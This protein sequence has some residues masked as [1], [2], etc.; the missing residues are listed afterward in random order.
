MENGKSSTPTTGEF[1]PGSD[2][3]LE[4]F[5][6]REGFIGPIKPQ[7]TATSSGCGSSLA[8]DVLTP[9]SDGAS[10]EA[11]CCNVLAPTCHQQAT[12]IR[13]V[14]ADTG[15]VQAAVPLVPLPAGPSPAHATEQPMAVQCTGAWGWLRTLHDILERGSLAVA[16]EHHQGAGSRREG[17]GTSS[18]SEKAS[19][20]RPLSPTPS[21]SHDTYGAASDA[22][23]S[24]QWHPGMPRRVAHIF[25]GP[26]QRADGLRQFTWLVYG[27]EVVEFDTLIDPVEGN[28]LDDGVLQHLLERIRAGE[29]AL[30]ILGTPCGTF[31][32]AR[33][34]KDGIPDGGPVQLRAIDFPEG[35]PGLSEQDQRIIDDSNE[36]VRRTV[37]LAR[38]AHEAGASFII[39]NPATRSDP[40]TDLYRWIWRSHASLW[41][42]PVI[43]RLMDEPWANMVTFPQCALSGDYQKWTSLLYSSDLHRLMEPLGHLRCT[44]TR[45]RKQAAGLDDEGKWRSADA[46]AYPAEMNARLAAVAAAKIEAMAAGLRVGSRKPHALQP[47]AA[48]A[49]VTAKATPPTSSLRRLEPEVQE[50]LQAEIF[51]DANAPPVTEWADAP[52]V[53]DA[54]PGPFTTDEL[55]P[56]GMQSKLRDFATGVKACFHAARRGRWRWARDHRP[57]P[58]HATEDECLHECG[59]GWI[60]AYSDSDSLWH[61]VQPSGW[62]D[63]PPPG[64]LDTAMIVQY[65]REN[66][67]SDM[68]IISFIAH[69][70]PGPDLEHCAVLGPPHVGALKNP[71]AF[72]KTAAKDREKGWVKYGYRLPPVWPMRADPMNIRRAQR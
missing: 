38:A 71:E 59:R 31:S 42:H 64:E 17:D 34:S 39:E 1:S 41:C 37:V 12:A 49:D 2:Q 53:A 20:K 32:V 70:Y 45:H 30:L 54:V 60:W 19:R 10:N 68:E 35:L 50:V 8:A 56:Q 55:I 11:T 27:Y 58:L 15:Q 40:K 69:G 14:H 47:E 7:R 72:D 44:H 36:L 13:A 5:G 18:P 65:A 26:G 66:G 33:I 62:P 25:S 57:A 24:T 6:A 46:A 61:A 67:Y 3:L 28:L 43:M 4:L 23:C 29:F 63:S 21:L 9:G 48:A 22:E 16:G 51:P 52:A